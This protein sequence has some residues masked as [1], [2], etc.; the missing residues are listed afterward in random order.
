MNQMV[1]AKSARVDHLIPLDI[2]H[3]IYRYADL[4]NPVL[5]CRYKV[6]QVNR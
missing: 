1:S 3:R 2:D 4:L 6:L 5:D